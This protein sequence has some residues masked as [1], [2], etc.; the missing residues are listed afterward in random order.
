MGVLMLAL[1][2]AVANLDVHAASGL[3]TLCAAAINTLAIVIF[4][5]RGV[6]DYR[7]GIPM[8]VAGI[9]GGYLGAHAVKKLDAQ[10]ARLGILIY[11]WALTA[12]FFIRLALG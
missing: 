6:L 10:K 9:A 5:A 3:R 12:Y 11:S 2:L 7:R 8:L 4:A 1:Y